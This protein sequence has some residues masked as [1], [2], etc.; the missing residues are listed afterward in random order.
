MVESGLRAG[1]TNLYTAVGK[2]SFQGIIQ[3]NGAISLSQGF[4]FTSM[5]LS[6]MSVFVIE[7][8]YWRASLWALTASVLSYFGIIHAYSLTNLGIGNKF[9][10]GAATEFAV[11]YAIISIFLLILHTRDR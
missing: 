1:G 2:G 6:A 4:I 3:I 8:E 9:G 5:I 7:R 10:F 11:C